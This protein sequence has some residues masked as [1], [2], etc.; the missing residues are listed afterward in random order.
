MKHKSGSMEY[1]ETKGEI[2]VKRAGYYF[3]YSQMFYADGGD[4]ILQMAHETYISGEKVM[5]SVESITSKDSHSRQHHTK[6][7][8]GVFHVKAN[9]TIFVAVTNT[10]RYL[11]HPIR[12]FF[13]AFLLHL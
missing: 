8:G 12:S 9:G 10:F 7:H 1:E 3:V 13:G 4:K 5:S 6:Y 11:V 2:K